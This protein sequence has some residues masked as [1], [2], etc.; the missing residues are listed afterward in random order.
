MKSWKTF[1][2]WIKSIYGADVVDI[3]SFDHYHLIWEWKNVY[4]Q[5]ILALYLQF[6]YQKHL[7]ITILSNWKLKRLTFILN[8]MLMIFIWM[9]ILKSEM[10]IV[11]EYEIWFW[12]SILFFGA[13]NLLWRLNSNHID[14]SKVSERLKSIV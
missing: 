3:T 11:F 12:Y 10:K 8:Q 14:T 9:K 6:Y 7:S 4:P 2:K 1:A 13:W 5:T